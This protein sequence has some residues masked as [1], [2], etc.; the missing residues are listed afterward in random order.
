[1]T[2]FKA[3]FTLSLVIILLILSILPTIY[4]PR[5]FANQGKEDIT[6]IYGDFDF[7]YIEKYKNTIVG[8]T[9]NI[10]STY[11]VYKS[12]F[13]FNNY[14]IAVSFPKM[15][16]NINEVKTFWGEEWMEGGEIVEY[17]GS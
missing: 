5:Y 10:T 4:L 2:K 14:Y 11:Y 15:S 17:A 9:Y 12:N 16:D 3:I 8:I 6:Q 13:I 1:M 7:I